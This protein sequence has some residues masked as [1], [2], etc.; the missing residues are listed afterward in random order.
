MDIQT[1]GKDLVDIFA[2]RSL[3]ALRNA[4][5]ED[6]REIVSG[7]VF[8]AQRTF[9]MGTALG[10]L[11]VGVAI[12]AGITA[13]VTPTSGPEL[14]KRVAR[15]TKNAGQRLSSMGT[16]VVSE[17]K[18]AGRAIEET[19]ERTVD[20]A[21]TTLDAAP[22][23]AK[24]RAKATKRLAKKS[25]VKRPAAGHP[26]LNRASGHAKRVTRQVHA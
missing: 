21:S 9:S 6:V 14:R 24:R 12:G 10:A 22:M 17:M 5:M 25:A 16:R 2:Q 20:L 26:H 4:R 11:A 7:R 18:S 19:V 23:P 13:L 1:Y 15:S 8:R 3:E